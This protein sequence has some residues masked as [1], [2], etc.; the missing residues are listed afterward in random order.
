MT[1]LKPCP[2]CG[3]HLERRTDMRAFGYNELI[4]GGAIFFHPYTDCFLD[5]FVINIGDIKQW[6]RRANNDTERTIG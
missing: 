3:C 5:G 6:E 2:F 1:D 4:Y